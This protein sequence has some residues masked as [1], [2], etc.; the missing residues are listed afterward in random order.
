MLSDLHL[1]QAYSPLPN[2]D[3]VSSSQT[4]NRLRQAT[5][6]NYLPN[7]AVLPTCREYQK[8]HNNL[9]AMLNVHL[10]T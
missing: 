3:D 10:E 8:R 7:I 1:Q 6:P 4:E 2:Q 9:L 5:C